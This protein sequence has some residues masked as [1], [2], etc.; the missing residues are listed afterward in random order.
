MS[1]SWINSWPSTHLP[2]SQE[3]RVREAAGLP[4][5][6]SW[7]K[8]PY[9]PEADGSHTVVYL[10]IHREMQYCSVHQKEKKNPTNFFYKFWTSIIHKN[11]ENLQPSFLPNS[12]RQGQGL[13]FKYILEL[14]LLKAST[15]GLFNGTDVLVELD[16]Q[17]VIIHTFHISDNGVV[18]LLCKGDEIVEAVNPAIQRDGSVVSNKSL[19]WK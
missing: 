11:Q 8:S 5:A 14:V 19:W 3:W 18:S 6:L 13:T 9:Q 10:A 4:S 1:S 7:I 12:Q 16:H 15:H 2:N 17:R